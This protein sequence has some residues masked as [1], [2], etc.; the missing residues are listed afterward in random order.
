MGGLTVDYVLNPFLAHFVGD[1]LLQTDAMAAQKKRS[2]LW[3]MAHVAA[4]MLPFLVCGLAWW[5][6]ALVAVQH[7][8]QDRTNFVVWL[9]R[10]KGSPG[11]A[12]VPWG[13]VVT[14]NTLHVLWIALIVA[15]G[16]GCAHG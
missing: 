15:L 14:D 5:Q 3:C 1:Y 9:M 10:V 12:N 8:A 2:S 6:L 13:V 7:Y 11:F 4:Y 16:G